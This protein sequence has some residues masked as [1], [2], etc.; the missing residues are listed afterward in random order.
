MEND[1]NK[2]NVT[3]GISA[4]LS[5]QPIDK[6][7]L[8]TNL[9]KVQYP[10]AQDEPLQQPKTTKDDNKSYNERMNEWLEKH[11]NEW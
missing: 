10:M 8:F 1:E 3:V 7:K 11:A 6:K 5:D 4:P 9:F 2:S